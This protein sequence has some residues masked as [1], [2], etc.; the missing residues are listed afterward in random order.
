YGRWTYKIEEAA[1]QGAAGVL[2]IHT[3]ESATYGWATV[4]GSWTGPQVRIESPA[5]SLLAA[6]W[7]TRDAAARIFSAAGLD[8]DAQ[9]TRAGRRGFRGV[10]VRGGVQAAVRSRIERSAT[11]NVI[12]RLPGSGATAHEA[13]MIGGHYD[14]LGI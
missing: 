3:D 14:H 7:L 12:A 8:L 1:R 13:V 4:A 10:P 6:G 5:T 2:L 9:M 11:A